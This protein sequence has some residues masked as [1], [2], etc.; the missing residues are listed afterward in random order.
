MPDCD[1]SG[2]NILNQNRSSPKLNNHICF[3]H[4]ALIRAQSLGI[5]EGGVGRGR[6]EK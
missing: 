1:V 2:G 4:G 5:A 6:T 3:K